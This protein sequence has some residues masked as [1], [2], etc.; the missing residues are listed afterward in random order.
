MTPRAEGLL[1]RC[2]R[3]FFRY[4]TAIFVAFI[5]SILSLFSTIWVPPF[6]FFG[7]RADLVVASI[8]IALVGFAGVI[9]GTF[10]LER[11]SRQF[12]SLVLLVLGLGFY[13]QLWLRLNY[14]RPE[15][16]PREFPH[17]WPLAIGGLVAVVFFFL[18][19][20]PNVKLGGSRFSS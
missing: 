18:K 5:V 13:S 12:G 7:E 15:Y 14:E 20:A 3:L 19:S 17:F 4:V 1:L 6:M 10:C 11:A 2:S 9:A 8:C 16:H